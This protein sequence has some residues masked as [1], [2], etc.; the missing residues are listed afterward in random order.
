M[1]DVRIELV[2]DLSPGACIQAFCDACSHSSLL[3]LATLKVRYG[4]GFPLAD[5]ER[6]ITCHRCGRRRATIR[7][8]HYA[9]QPSEAFRSTVFLPR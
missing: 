9:P 7:L 8:T 6:R 1:R 4:S 3:T 5:V 2:G